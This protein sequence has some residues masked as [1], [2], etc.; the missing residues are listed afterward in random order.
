MVASTGD[1]LG[2]KMLK[3]ALP[4]LDD[5][6]ADLPWQPDGDPADGSLVTQIVGAKLE[7]LAVHADPRGELVELLTTRDTNCE[8]IVHVY[9]V[10][11]APGSVRAWVYHKHQ[12]DR[13]AYTE[14]HFQIVLFDIRP[15]SPTRGMLEEHHLGGAHPARLTI[16][17]GVVHGVKNCGS[18]PASFVNMPTRAYDPAAPDKHRIHYPDP[19]VPFSFE[20]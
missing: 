14:G 6:R 4:S 9:R 16:P 11:A 13:L 18:A 19:R 12:E 3:H 10:T 2:A 7:P 20:A 1:I 5:F 15:D 8:D 17:R